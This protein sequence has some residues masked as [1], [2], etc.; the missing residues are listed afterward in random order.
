MRK[1][2]KI[3]QEELAANCNV[4]VR[5]IQRLEKGEQNVTIELFFAISSNL[6]TSPEDLIKFG[7]KTN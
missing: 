2:Q 7:V 6:K 5:T 4:D 3:S 1:E